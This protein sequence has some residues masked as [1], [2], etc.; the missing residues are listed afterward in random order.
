M[1]PGETYFPTYSCLKI[2]NGGIR[3]FLNRPIN[4]GKS[5]LLIVLFRL[6]IYLKRKQFTWASLVFLIV[7]EIGS[8]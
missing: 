8:L 5:S 2:E 7:D 3:S 4:L 1:A 6:P